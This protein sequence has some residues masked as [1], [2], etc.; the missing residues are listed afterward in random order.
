MHWDTLWKANWAAGSIG[1]LERMEKKNILR[2]LLLTLGVVLSFLT[3]AEVGLRIFRFPTYRMTPEQLRHD[4][5]HERLHRSSSVPGLDYELVPNL[6]NFFHGEM[7][8][9]NS[10]GMRDDEPQPEGDDSL[11]RIAVLGDSFTFGLGVPDNRTY[12]NALENL[13]NTRIDGEKFEVLNFGVSGYSTR[14]EAL[15]LK[16]KAMDW[17]LDLVVVG[18]YLNDPEIEPAQPLHS[19]YQDPRWWQHSNL[20]RLVAQNKHKWDMWRLGSGDYLRYLHATEGG[21]WQSVVEALGD[22]EQL[23][24][25]REI[26]VLLVIFPYVTIATWADYAYED[27]HE[28]VRDAAIATGIYAL[29]LR[30]DFSKYPAD[31]LIVGKKNRHPS[32]VGHRAAAMAIYKWI[33]KHKDQ[34][35]FSGPT[36]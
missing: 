25:E 32:V 20:L 6:R 28:Q 19:Y 33:V 14:D 15:V 34:L 11:H 30:D 8:T 9:T 23:A 21:K 22:I 2:S 35:G 24:A 29:D 17:D 1:M 26:P 12:S 16:Y 7:I 5:W 36:H 10:L 3:V 27:L 4:I 31:L 13:L 18:Y